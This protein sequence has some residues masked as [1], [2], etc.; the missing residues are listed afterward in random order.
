MQEC[1]DFYFPLC[2][3]WFG[4]PDDLKTRPDQQKY[5]IRG[6]TNDE[7]RQI[8]LSRVV[9][10]SESVGIKIPAHYDAELGKFVLDY[11]APIRLNEET[12]T[13]DYNDTMSWEEQLKI[14]KRGSKHK[15][16]SITDVQTESWG[17]ELW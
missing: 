14:W 8:W 10:Y 2:A 9:P 13:W 15:V 16:P 11:E 17:T 5:R 4:L 12:R 3:S 7:M 1:V 6:G